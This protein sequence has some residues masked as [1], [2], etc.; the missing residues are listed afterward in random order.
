MS[1]KGVIIDV[2]AETKSI[3][4]CISGITKEAQP[5]YTPENGF[6]GGNGTYRVG[7]TEVERYLYLIVKI[8]GHP[9]AFVDVR[10]RSLVLNNRQNVT[11]AFVSELKKNLKGKSVSIKETTEGEFTLLNDSILALES[12]QDVSL[13]DALKVRLKPLR[14]EAKEL[15]GNNVFT[16]EL[17]GVKVYVW[18][19]AEYAQI[20]FYS[21]FL[22]LKPL[23]T[24]L[25]GNLNEIKAEY[26]LADEVSEDGNWMYI[27]FPEGS[28]VDYWTK[29]ENAAKKLLDMV[30]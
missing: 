19:E 3:S 27:D 30:R 29:V 12:A 11:D 13:Y 18:G 21:E 20:G 1:Y 23:N 26:S 17:S 22:Y 9:H 25:K 8:K 7:Y 15:E 16:K 2:K 6:H 24:K 28:G 10:K 5:Y 14:F 4:F